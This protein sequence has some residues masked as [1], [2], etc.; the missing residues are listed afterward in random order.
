[1]NLSKSQ[2]L[3]LKTEQII[4]GTVNVCSA[5]SIISK[6][7]D[8]EE[9][10]KAANTIFKINDAL[11]IRLINKNGVFEQVVEEYREQDFDVIYVEKEEE[12][13]DYAEK[14]TE[15]PFDIT[16]QLCFITLF[17][18]DSFCGV[19]YKYHHLVF[20]AWTPSLV[21]TQFNKLIAGEDVAAESFF[22][23]VL[24]ENE[25][26]KSKKYIKDKQFFLNVF[27]KHPESTFFVDVETQ[28]FYTV[29]KTFTIGEEKA[30]KI[31]KFCLDN[32][33]SPYNLFLSAF[34]FCYSKLRENVENFY[35]GTPVLNRSTP[36]DRNTVG[37]FINT[38][39][40]I[41]E[42]DY[43]CSVFKNLENIKDNIFSVMRHQRFAVDD[44]MEELHNEYNY[45]DRLYDVIF[46][47][48][49]AQIFG[50][51]VQGKWHP[52][53]TQGESLQ[54]HI[55]D[56]N[57][58]GV[59]VIDFDYQTAK[60]SE[61]DVENLFNYMYKVVFDIIENKD[62]KLCNIEI[63]TDEEKLLLNEFNDTK[64]EYDKTRS[65]I[66]VF[67]SCVNNNP[68]KI[69]IV[70][71]DRT[72]TFSELNAEANRIAHTLL[73]KGV[74]SGD[75][76]GLMLPRKSYLLSTIIG[77]LKTGAAYLP[78][79]PEYP[80]KR[81]EF[82]LKDSN[83]KLCITEN[84][85]NEFLN[86]DNEENIGIKIPVENNYCIIYTSGSTGVPKG[87]FLKHKGIVN[88]CIN[89]NVVS[90]FNKIGVEPISISINN[91]TFDYFIAEN[92]VMLLNGYKT[93][94]CSKENSVKPK[95]FWSLCK[96]HDVNLIQTTPTRY[97]ILL[98]KEFITKDIDIKLAVTSGEPLLPELYGKISDCLNCEIFNPLGP[99][100]CT[101]WVPNGEGI[102]KSNIHL[103]KPF[104]NTQ[105]YILDKYLK[106]TPIGVIGELCIAGD[107]VG[108]GYLNRPELNKEKFIDNPFGEGKLY[109][110]S[111]LVY[112][113]KDGNIVYVGRNDF[114]VKIRG[115]RIEL[116]EIENAISNVGGISQ[117]VVVVRKD[118]NDKQYI[119]AFYTGEKTDNRDIKAEISTHLPKH[120]V[121]HSIVHLDSLPMTASGKIDRKDLPEID[122]SS[123][124]EEIE[125]VAPATQKEIALVKALS[126][127]LN[128]ERVSMIDNFFNIGGDSIHAIYV[129][130]ALEDMNYSLQVA[131]IMQSDTLADIVLCM[132]STADID[133]YDQNEVNDL[134]P[135]T[136]IM[137]AYLK[138][139]NTIAK[140]F[141]HTGIISTDCDED[142]VKRAFDILVSHHDML[143]GILTDN[144][145]GTV[146][147]D[148]RQAYSFQSITINDKDEATEYIKNT[149][150]DDTLVKI[151][152]CKTEKEKLVGITIHHFLIDLVS[153]EILMKD[154]ATVVNQIK[155]GKEISLSAKSASFR[156]W[157]EELRKY[158]ETKENK[159]YWE[160]INQ[161][162]DNTQSLNI[163]EDENDAEEFSF[164]FDKD[165]STKL[166]NDVNR[167]YGTRTN[168]V[169]VT[170]IGLAAGKLAGGSVGIMVESHGRT[171]LPKSISVEHTIGWFTSCYPVVIENKGN[172]A[173]ELISTKDTLR[174]IPRCGVEYLLLT[175]GFHSN[176]DII[177]NFYKNGIS[178]ENRDNKLI[179]F[180]GNSVFPG[181][182]NVNC[183]VSNNLLSIEIT[184]PKCK[185]RPNISE[186]LGME[187]VAQIRDIVDLCTTTDA[188]VKTRSDFSDD[189]LTQSELDELNRLFD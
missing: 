102:S 155:S 136:P 72:L 112:W 124:S 48:Q 41:I 109:R 7:L 110:S 107:S 185:H 167:K 111:D 46:S 64:V 114:Q 59:F 70:A 91:V 108:G 169:L 8:V 171:S 106:P 33:V 63:I 126:T 14:Q 145:I 11:R 115:L 135:F 173:D 130:S 85:I 170:A 6:K 188:V 158:D 160:S 122:F 37:L 28:D 83:S 99:S 175:G 154:F 30:E 15:I 76:V 42:L 117:C 49:N 178:N 10:K 101:V 164:I 180:G 29:R 88:F 142:I 187:F 16:G 80:Q 103:G 176:T 56:R 140:D 39:P 66:D 53:N 51:N 179:D 45:S 36:K 163:Q 18:S 81:I 84:N 172:I 125:Y 12:V 26:I 27:E 174:K 147:S 161:K 92:I 87:C 52:K 181:R 95:E 100:E 113:D 34:S 121:P 128:V 186:E 9:M 153:W 120:M 162:L 183:I 71:N 159:E 104:A 23:H 73:D 146:P 3:I 138:E 157:N 89:N 144:G 54:V 137:R 60:F 21:A 75:I 38:V 133:N 93:V 132:E 50:D 69:A 55:N 98:N 96:E 40:I 127:V 150:L 94:L 139:R 165:I 47:Y 182:I 5:S 79:D 44:L 61:K 2:K 166:I 58:E 20:D 25:Y 123:I 189:T 134:I 82:M 131:D 97:K 116:G 168:E 119:C 67:E 184:V 129:V 62:E 65:V 152:F 4:G 143:R 43:N 32:S 118:E 19:L 148:K 86:N 17:V 31:R 149:S 13:W 24:D 105:V 74:R 35:I 1:M 177:F 68:N 156:L 90:Y 77:I 141:V 22:D 57:R 78:V 151:V